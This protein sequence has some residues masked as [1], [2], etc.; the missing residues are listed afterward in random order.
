MGS[1]NLTCGVSNASLNCGAKVK[2]FFIT[3]NA[4]KDR[5]IICHNT[6]LHA[7]ISLPVDATY[8]DYGRYKITNPEDP[9]VALVNE[10]LQTSAVPMEEG[11]NKYHEQEVIPSK[12]DICEDYFWDRIND[13]RIMFKQRFGPINTQLVS[14]FAIL[15]PVFDRL[16]NNVCIDNWYTGGRVNEKYYRKELLKRFKNSRKYMRGLLIEEGDTRKDGSVF[17]RKDVIQ[18]NK[19][20]VIWSLADSMRE[21]RMFDGDPASL[22][23]DMYDNPNRVIKE[24]CKMRLLFVVMDQAQIMWQP[25]MSSGQE[26]DFKSHIEILAEIARGVHD[27][28]RVNDNDLEY[29]EEDNETAQ[30]FD[31]ATKAFLEK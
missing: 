4:Y 12:L 19:Q 14:P 21:D 31:P 25:M 28:M 23:F 24:W 2:L 11:D 5:G 22:A 6:D 3:E 7:P 10:L 1:F 26:V 16:L 27:H 17:T 30:E 29:D 18:Q 13:G 15:E 8:N 20:N 9:A